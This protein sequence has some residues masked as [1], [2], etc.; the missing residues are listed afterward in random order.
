MSVKSA[1]NKGSQVLKGV[2]YWCRERV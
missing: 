2:W 1:G